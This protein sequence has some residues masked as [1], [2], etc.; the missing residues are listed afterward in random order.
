MRTRGELM[1]SAGSKN[2]GAMAAIMGQDEAKILELCE[3]VKDAGTVVPA[4][5]NCPGQI[6][7]SGAVAGVNKLVE[8]CAA[9]GIKAIP[10]A[11]SGAFHSPLMQFAQAGLA[12]AIAKTKFNDVEKPVIANV[13]AEPVTKGAEL[14]ELLVKQLV[15]PVRWN[16]CMNKAMSLGVTQGVEVGSGKVLMGLMRKISR[17][18]KV[19]PVETI[20]A[21]EALK[22]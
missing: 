12:E 9:A 22:G 10:L 4:N 5:I 2:P 17:D 16:D 20:E 3:A 8:N 19:T 6:V 13:I 1:A 21:F 7:V 14:A 11:V 15:S 18:V